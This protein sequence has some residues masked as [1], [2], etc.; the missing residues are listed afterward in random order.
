MVWRRCCAILPRTAYKIRTKIIIKNKY[1]QTNL[2]FV[3]VCCVTYVNLLEIILNFDT[4]YAATKTTSMYF[5]HILSSSSSKPTWCWM[6]N[7]C[8][9]WHMRANKHRRRYLVNGCQHLVDQK[10][11]PFLMAQCI[12]TYNI[13]RP[14]Y[15]EFTNL[16]TMS[17]FTG[18]L[19]MRWIC[20]ARGLVRVLFLS[21]WE[22]VI[23]K[24]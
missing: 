7:S 22:Y 23:T 4:F 14:M 19:T 12:Y 13:Y 8:V 5:V 17:T 15:K 11:I 20:A 16:P 24:Y 1:Q 18:Q 10:C 6:F 2:Q 21:H 3:Y 9:V